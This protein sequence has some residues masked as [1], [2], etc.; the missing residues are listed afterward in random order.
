[1][2]FIP[3]AALAFVAI[4]ALAYLVKRVGF[5]EWTF[6]LALATNLVFSVYALWVHFIVLIPVLLF[7]ARRDWRLALIPWSVSW[8]LPFTPRGATWLGMIYPLTLF[9]VLWLIVLWGSRP[10]AA[11]TR[12]APRAG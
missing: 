2:P 10:T 8:L 3:L 1:M 9:I 12:L 4:L 7:L 11:S 6:G 5:N